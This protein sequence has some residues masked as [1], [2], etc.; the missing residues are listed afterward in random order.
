MKIPRSYRPFY[1]SLYFT[2]WKFK[3][4]SV[5]NFFIQQMDFGSKKQKEK[6]GKETKKIRKILKISNMNNDEIE[7]I[8]LNE[9]QKITIEKNKIDYKVYDFK[10]QEIIKNFENKI[11]K[12]FDNS[13]SIETFNN[14][15]VIKDKKNFKLSDLA[16]VVIKSS[17]L[18]YFYPYMINDIQKIIHNLKIKDNSW[19][20]IA[21]NDNQSILLQIPPLTNEAKLKKKKEA[22]DLLE[23]IKGDIRNIRHKIRDD[24]IKNIEG[25]EWKV[26][27]KNKLDNYIKTK[28]KNIE[29]IYENSIKNI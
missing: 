20:P 2:K 6:I 21:S 19:N 14:I 22:K 7:S 5:Y 29:N 26:V 11:K 24:I 18:I 13:L 3:F 17:S 9:K 1:Q 15:S 4:C 16:Q 23:K 27:E 12:I 28:I 10:L 8:N 25:E